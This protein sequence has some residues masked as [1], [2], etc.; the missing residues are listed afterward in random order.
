MQALSKFS[1]NNYLL[2]PTKIIPVDIRIFTQM[3]YVSSELAPKLIK[4]I[5]DSYN[6]LYGENKISV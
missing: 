1:L 2:E 6:I 3:I 4:T 5:L